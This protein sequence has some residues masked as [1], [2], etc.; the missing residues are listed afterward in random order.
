MST[1]LAHIHQTDQQTVEQHLTQVASLCSQLA[2]KI[3]TP[4]AGSL[5]GLMHDFG[6]YS[7]AFQNY[8]QSAEGLLDPD[9]DE[10]SYI[11]PKAAKGKIDHSTAGAQWIFKAYG[12]YLKQNPLPQNEMQ[13]AFTV[14]QIL[15]TC[16]ASHHSGLI[17]ALGSSA[18]SGGF[19]LRIKKA[20]NL[21]HITECTSNADQSVLKQAQNLIT[22]GALEQSLEQ[23]KAIT[24]ELQQGYSI[25]KTSQ[26]FYIGM[27]TK[28]L[29]SCLIEADRF[30][31]ACF[32]EPEYAKHPPFSSTNWTSLCD[33]LEVT[34]SRF[35][36]DSPMN[37]IRAHIARQ[38][39]QKADDSQGIYSLTVPTGGGKTL[40]S[41][42]YALH[43]AAKHQLDRIIY[44]IPYTSIIEQNAEAIRQALPEYQDLIFEHHSN[45]DPEQKSWRSKIVGESWQA[46]IILTTMVQFLETLFKHNT[47]NARRLHQ[48]SRS[49]LIFD[50]IQTLPIP[51]VHLFCNA[52]NFLSLH[53]RTTSILCTATQ[54]LL[55]Q[56]EHPEW[57]QL[58]LKEDLMG[59]QNAIQKLF[60]D[61]KRVQ[62]I[63]QTRIGGWSKEDIVDLIQ[64]Q[65]ETRTSCLVITNTKA[66]A[67][68]IFIAA[69]NM[70]EADSIFHLSTSMCAQHRK[71]I[72]QQI[73][74]RLQDKLPV[75]CISTQLIE[76]GVDLDF[77]TVIRFLAGLDS[78]AQAAGRC[79]RHGQRSQGEVY[80]INPDQESLTQLKEIRIG[81]EQTQR[82]LHEC[83]G[84][85]LLE[86]HVMQRYFDYAFFARKDEMFYK[87]NDPQSSLLNLLSEN[88][89]HNQHNTLPSTLKQSFM[90]AGK[91]FNVID[92]PT[93]AVIVPYQE[94]AELIIQLCQL[95]F[96]SNPSVYR[97]LLHQAQQYSINVFPF[98]LDELLKK[99]A[100]QALSKHQQDLSSIYY[101]EKNFYDSQ[102]G[103]SSEGCS[104]QSSYII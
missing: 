35:T 30:D 60:D 39:Q 82:I 47:K 11:D 10:D 65:M 78:I 58:H 6:K 88:Q 104:V 34:L 70:Y 51:C 84:Q 102:F 29:F 23:V 33:A 91:F 89:G 55:H 36:A 68:D 1:F 92:A 73:K 99:G 94:G 13:Q 19:R 22:Q 81:Q 2:N 41:L 32:A 3:N 64:Q 96:K 38:C 71:Q 48:L 101:L 54:P 50:E 28:F 72:F 76:A 100:I 95:D 31:S 45:L 21:T 57:G 56:L 59:D 83:K 103:L 46:P 14:V 69:Q 93:Q 16:V 66:W 61:L 97:D 87:I 4:L 86:P 17:D 27:Y 98:M 20:D 15:S 77:D 85:N 40:A 8:I 43:H 24:Q 18:D 53:A 52:I 12:A 9:R 80:I 42:R 79:N 49:V 75:L 37:K 67:K 74:Q 5:I 7:R 62:V 26:A 90:T 63:D 25:S 44:I